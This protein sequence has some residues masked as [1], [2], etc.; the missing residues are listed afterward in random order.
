MSR[1]YAE[2]LQKE[3][4]VDMRKWCQRPGKRTEDGKIQYFTQQNHKRECDVNWIIRKY[5]KTGIL[6]HVQRI[7]ARY[8]DVTGA[9]FR[10]AQDLFI[11]AHNMFNDLPA[12]IKKRFRQSPA[13]FLEF[14]ENP[15]NRDEAIKLGLIKAD[16]PPEKDGLGEHVSADDYKEIEEEKEKKKA[17][18]K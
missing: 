15:A 16:S 5:D 2:K 6:D 13:E 17:A 9:D 8:G 18:E 12:D 4:K 1:A 7:E 11:N 14:M 10:K 3:K